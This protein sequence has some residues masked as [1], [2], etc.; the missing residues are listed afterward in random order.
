M[1]FWDIRK[2]NEPV[3]KIIL[4]PNRTRTPTLKDGAPSSCV[5][6]DQGIVIFVWIK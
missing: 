2:W 6:F 3:E 5:D 1:I 4:D